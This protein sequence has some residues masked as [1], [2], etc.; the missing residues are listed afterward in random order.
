M[1][2][3]PLELAV[4][5]T[6]AWGVDPKAIPPTLVAATPVGTLGR[7]AGV[8]LEVER[9]SDAAKPGKDA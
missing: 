2:E 7:V 4:Q 6:V 8:M 9:R 3:P 1:G 5:E